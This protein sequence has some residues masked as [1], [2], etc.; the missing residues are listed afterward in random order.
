MF[1]RTLFRKIDRCAKCNKKAEYLYEE[2]R[3][4]GVNISI[5]LCNE[6]ALIKS[7]EILEETGI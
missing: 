4:W 6:H 1:R 5:Q 3:F 2:K 7:K